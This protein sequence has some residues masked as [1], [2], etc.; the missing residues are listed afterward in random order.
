MGRSQ[1]MNVA[2]GMKAAIPLIRQSRALLPGAFQKHS[3][4]CSLLASRC[5]GSGVREPS[6]LQDR[7]EKD[8][9]ITTLMDAKKRQGLTFDSIAHE[10]GYTNAFTAQL[11]LLQAPLPAS[12]APKLQEILPSLP[13]SVIEEM[14]KTPNRRFDVDIVQEPSVYRLMEAVQHYGEGFKILLNEKFGD[15]IMSAIDFYMTVHKIKGKAGED[16]VV[17]VLNG[18]WLPYTEQIA[19]NNTANIDT[20]TRTISK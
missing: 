4:R 18:K 17:V 19:A 5:F 1:T 14:Q 11:F 7:N 12:A 20:I 9:I 6:F 13:P 2:N 10:L 16:R 3:W 15:G 8:D